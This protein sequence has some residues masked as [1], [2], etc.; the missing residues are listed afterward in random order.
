[1]SSHVNIVCEWKTF[2]GYKTFA[3]IFF[4]PT[5]SRFFEALVKWHGSHKLH[6]SFGIYRPWNI[7]L[8]LD[9]YIMSVEYT[10]DIILVLCP[11]FILGIFWIQLQLTFIVLLLKILCSLWDF[12]KCLLINRGNIFSIFVDTDLLNGGLDQI[13]FRDLCFGFSRWFLMYSKSTL[14]PLFSIAPSYSHFAVLHISSL[15]EFFDSL[16]WMEFII[17]LMTFGWWFH[18]LWM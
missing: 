5:Q 4:L 8:L 16:S 6:P 13:I 3:S 15:E 7:L 11:L 18:T 17:C 14:N 12:G 9:N 10:V 2:Y 1:M